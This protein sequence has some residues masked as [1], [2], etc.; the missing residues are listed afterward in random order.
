[1]ESNK[2]E[3][4]HY[5]L[6]QDNYLEKDNEAQKG[7]SWFWKLQHE[8]IICKVCGQKWYHYLPFDTYYRRFNYYETI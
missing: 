3:I 6:D 2:L 8:R 4:G 5:C 7:K 1:M